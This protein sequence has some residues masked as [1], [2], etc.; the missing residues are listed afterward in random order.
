M[1]QLGSNTKPGG[2][3]EKWRRKEERK[4]GGIGRIG[5]EFS[6]RS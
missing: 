5:L 1:C 3:G 6:C 4:G 2:P